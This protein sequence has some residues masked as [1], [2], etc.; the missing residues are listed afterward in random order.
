[1]K[2]ITSGHLGFNLFFTAACVVMVSFSSLF[3]QT[4]R[5]GAVEITAVTQATPPRIMLQW[6][7]NSFFKGV[8]YHLFKRPLETQPATGENA[9]S[10]NVTYDFLKLFLD[11]PFASR[12]NSGFNI[13][14]SGYFKLFLETSP[15]DRNNLIALLAGTATNYTDTNVVAG[16]SYE[17]SISDTGMK[18]YKVIGHLVTGIKAPLREDRGA[19]L[20]LVDE[21]VSES[22]APELARF[23]HD[24]AGDGW[25]VVSRK[26]PRMQINRNSPGKDAGRARSNEVDGI[27]RII[28]QVYRDNPTRLKQVIIIGHVAIPYAGFSC[29]DEHKDHMGA[30]PAD[31][32]YGDI[33]PEDGTGCGY[34]WPDDTP[35]PAGYSASA[36]MSND[37]ADGKFD[38]V[39]SIFRPM[40]PELAVGRIDF[41][42]MTVFPNIN[43]TEITL[44]KRY[45]DRNHAYRYRV[46]PNYTE[47][48][49]RRML[50]DDNFGYYRDD[51]TARWNGAFA[52]SAWRNGTALFGFGGVQALDW[53]TELACNRYLMAYG[54][55]AGSHQSANGIG[56]S[57]DFGLKP[58]KAVFNL[59]FG[60]YFGDW[61]SANNF[62]R[63]SLAGT[64]QSMGLAA[65][66]DGRPA[67]N[68]TR[69]AMGDTIGT[70]WQDTIASCPWMGL[71]GDPSLRLYMLAPVTDLRASSAHNRASLHWTPS[72]DDGILG[73]AVYRS[74]QPQGPFV[75]LNGDILTDSGYTDA[76]CRAGSNYT[77]MV[78]VIR[79]ESSAGGSY[80]N[81]SQGQFVTLKIHDGEATPCN[82]IRMQSSVN[83]DASIMLSWENHA[84]NATG[85]RIERRVGFR[86][87]WETAANINARMTNYP[88]SFILESTNVYYRVCA[89]NTNGESPWSDETEVS[90]LR[91]QVFFP[92]A[93]LHVNRQDGA[94]SVRVRRQD[95]ESGPAGIEYVVSDQTAFAGIHY[96]SKAVGQ[97][98]WR[99]G[100]SYSGENGDALIQVT[101]I[102]SGKPHLPKTLSIN[103]RNPTPGLTVGI[104]SNM[105]ITIHDKEACLLPAPWKSKY[106]GHVYRNSTAVT[107]MTYRAEEGWSLHC[108]GTA[109]MSKNSESFRYAYMP[110]TG[111][112]WIKVRVISITNADM[113]NANAGLMMRESLSNGAAAMGLMIA[114]SAKSGLKL[115]WRARAN[116]AVSNQTISG[117]ALPVW[118]KLKHERNVWT[119][120]FSTNGSQWIEAGQTCIGAATSA[121]MGL[122]FTPASGR[123][124]GTAFFDSLEYIPNIRAAENGNAKRGNNDGEK[125]EK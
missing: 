21:T 109:M 94:V 1:M 112:G 37:V 54:C 41:H 125:P 26:A 102:Y 65:L 31:V 113:Q 47:E 111:N 4:A 123:E 78:R 48:I 52:A 11:T 19:I 110:L 97:A 67:C 56:T 24:L 101:P 2:K 96:T 20:L 79:L 87:S 8:A 64:G 73:Y 86:G 76:A 13:I 38:D 121:W 17:Y 51:A 40:R 27:K 42:A 117:I 77:Y 100:E 105:T 116:E 23:E 106:F 35:W 66:W 5:D 90:A 44:L 30:W 22:L 119:A 43:A 57:A 9:G 32:F 33:S 28:Q 14:S 68:L 95:G 6:K 10:I 115:I 7:S 91:G 114:P 18:Y 83:E 107:G 103:L 120:S 70:T 16:V 88:D 53:F 3:A 62:L 58:S 108:A 92:E 118:L 25:N 124:P 15:A 89:Y 85:L 45:L 34:Y 71:M 36:S 49:P 29:L 61:D 84:T 80:Y 98:R 60:S 39:T 122:A 104:P 55:G 50:V 81:A 93:R 82:P 46:G 75:R 12:V 69:M 63:A 72:R 59:L 99:H 74:D